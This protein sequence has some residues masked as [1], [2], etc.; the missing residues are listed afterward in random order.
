MLWSLTLYFTQ[1]SDQFE[2]W[3]AVLEHVTE[4][5]IQ[6]TAV[7]RQMDETVYESP[8]QLAT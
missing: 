6:T 4:P 7:R 1:R 8:Q 2:I 5:Q 3:I